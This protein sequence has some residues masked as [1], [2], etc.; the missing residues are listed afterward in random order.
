MVGAA[1]HNEVN[2]ADYRGTE[3]FGESVPAWLFRDNKCTCISMQVTK[4]H[5]I[6]TGEHGSECV[7]NQVLTSD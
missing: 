7:C 3:N 5:L 4:F 2:G 6:L 1:M